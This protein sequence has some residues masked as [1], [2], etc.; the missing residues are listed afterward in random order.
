MAR[1]G[2]GDTLLPVLKNEVRKVRTALW[3]R[4]SAFCVAAALAAVLLATLAA[5]LPRGSLAWLPE[6]GVD[7]VSEL[8]KLLA[9]GMLTVATVTL[10]VLM[11]VLSLAAAQV[12]PRAVPEV[13]A[14]QV[15]QNALGSFLATFVYSLTALLLLGFGAVSGPGLTLVVFGA[16]LLALNA[17]RY[18]V[19]WSHHVA[20]VLKVNRMIHRIHRQAAGVLDSYLDG[21]RHARC[22][23]S[24]VAPRQSLAVHPQNTGYVQMI[25]A[26]SLELL[27]CDHD[28]TVRLRVQEGDFVHPH[29]S[30][31]EVSSN[32]EVAAEEEA[33]LE[34]LRAAIVIG[35]ERRRESDPRLGFELLAEIACRSMSPAVN[36]PQSA[37]A[38]VDYL[39]ALLTAAASRPPADYPPSHSADGRVEFVRS[40]FASLLQLAFRP[41]MRDGGGAAEVI[42]A[43]MGVLRLLAVQAAP[44][45]LDCL[46]VEARR[47]EDLGE[48]ALPLAADKQAL[49]EMAAELRRIV[50]QRRSSG[51]R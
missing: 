26:A 20:E 32:G 4:P 16:L 45:Y 9:A 30:L 17:V 41:V 38:C 23:A 48:Q 44:D 21:E 46:A 6:V 39:G 25:D 27:A 5:V 15:T 36:D 35:F 13:M 42:C 40:D 31:M 28:L 12:S 14:D 8:L 18:L 7:A 2:S 11:L 43:I 24:V 49:G 51:A 50:A 3:L 22:D 47:A 19:Q 29:R 10:S 33:L 37:R 1:T 34:G